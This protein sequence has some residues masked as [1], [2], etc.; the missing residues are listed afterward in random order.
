M[1]DANQSEIDVFHT[2]KLEDLA[3]VKKLLTFLNGQ[4]VNSAVRSVLTFMFDKHIELLNS[5]NS[6][7]LYRL[8]EFL[9][10]SE[11]PFGSD[12]VQRS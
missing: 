9:M 8:F 6:V 12:N 11:G 1:K 2:L 3:E 5:E 10:T 4:Y 7:H